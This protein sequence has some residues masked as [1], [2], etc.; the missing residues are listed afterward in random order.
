MQKYRVTIIMSTSRLSLFFFYAI[1]IILVNPTINAQRDPYVLHE[2]STTGNVTSNS[3][4]R[5]N[6][7]T[8][9]STLSSNTQINYG[10]YSFSAGEGTNK[11]YATGLCKADLTTTDCGTC[12]SNSAHE[13]LELFP[14]EKEGI[15][16]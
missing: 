13:L 1:L 7:N 9:I 16:W 15:M 10:F 12:V 2:C 6:L 3:T 5:E 14:N 11:V 8:L 4:L